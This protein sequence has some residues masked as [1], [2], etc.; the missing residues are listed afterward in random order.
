MNVTWEDYKKSLGSKNTENEKF[1]RMIEE[2]CRII[3]RLKELRLNCG[4]SQEDL[5]QCSGMKQS[6]I[7]RIENMQSIPNLETIIRLTESLNCKIEIFS[8]RFQ[9]NIV[10]TELNTPLSYNKNEASGQYEIKSIGFKFNSNYSLGER[11]KWE[12]VN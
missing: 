11:K 3:K 6:A 8:R 2:E 9:D 10:V 7:A 1:F 12:A 4:M 5:A